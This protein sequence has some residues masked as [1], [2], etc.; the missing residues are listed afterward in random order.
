MRIL[1]TGAAGRVGSTVARG[2]QAR[3]EVRGHDRVP[4]PDLADT[5][6]SDLADFDS[7]LEATRGMDAVATLG[8]CP[9]VTSGRPCYRATSSARTTCLRLPAKTASSASPMPA[10]PGS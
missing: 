4:M 8:V 1:V 7:M 3:H 2:L 5:V 6:V 9:A 10:A